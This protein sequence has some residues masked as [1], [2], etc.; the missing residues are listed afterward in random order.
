[1]D[2]KKTHT[3]TTN[4]FHPYSSSKRTST[5]HTSKPSSPSN[6]LSVNELKKRIRDV[7]RLL[8]H[9]NLPPDARIVQ[10]RALAGYETDLKTETERR[11]RSEMV[12]KYHFVRFLGMFL[13]YLSFM[14]ILQKREIMMLTI[15]RGM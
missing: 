14:S 2:R 1:M 8:S 13:F 4:R 6:T 3:T 5:S 15:N 11:G 7:K 12:K 10:E 9:A